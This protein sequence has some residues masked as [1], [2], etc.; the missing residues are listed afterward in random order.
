[1]KSK[2]IILVSEL[3]LPQLLDQNTMYK[4]ESTFPTT[5]ELSWCEKLAIKGTQMVN[6]VKEMRHYHN[7][8]RK[9]DHSAYIILLGRILP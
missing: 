4:T 6:I 2:M 5:N 3:M 9:L 1:M 8:H 7:A